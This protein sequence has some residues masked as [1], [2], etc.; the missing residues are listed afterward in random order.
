M[1][2]DAKVVEA[3]GAFVRLI[4]RRP[5][6]YKFSADHGDT[7]IPGLVVLDAEGKVVASLP[8]PAEDAAKIASFLS[9]E[10]K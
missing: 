7:P 6:A 10:S 4:L 8:L 2:G 3:T 1:L 9:E 5:H